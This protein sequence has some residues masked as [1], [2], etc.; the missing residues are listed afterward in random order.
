MSFDAVLRRPYPFELYNV[1]VDG[2]GVRQDYRKV[3]CNFDA[4]L[5]NEGV[6]DVARFDY[7]ND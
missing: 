6:R 1:A 5:K 3:I 7:H 2:C 4:V